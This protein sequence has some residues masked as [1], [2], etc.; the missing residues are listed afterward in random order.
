MIQMKVS[1]FV[2][3]KTFAAAI[4]AALAVIALSPVN[5]APA[6]LVGMGHHGGSN[7]NGGANSNTAGGRHS[8]EAFSA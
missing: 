2:T 8:S 6:S 7:T 1:A 5:E 3:M 4:A